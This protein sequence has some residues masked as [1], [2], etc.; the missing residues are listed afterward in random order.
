M[1]PELSL[2]LVSSAQRS[3]VAM[4]S[5]STSPFTGGQQVQDW[6]GRYWSYQFDMAR[7]QNSNAKAMDAFI[8]NLGG[9]AGKFIFR[10]PSI[11]QSLA[12]SP[13]VAFAGQSGASLATDGWPVD[14]TVM[15]VG[16]FFSIGSGAETR[17]HQVNADIVSNG[18][19]FATLTFHPPLRSSP[20]DN[21]ELNITE[22]GVVLRLSGSVPAQIDTAQFYQFS[23]SAREA[24]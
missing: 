6:G 20:A 19:G 9:L 3:L 7:M 23:I 10:D 16:D 13:Q 15:Q 8:N 1:I 5:A 14:A 2:T 4:T 12:G 22:P 17:L 11:R 18:S 24:I 21:A